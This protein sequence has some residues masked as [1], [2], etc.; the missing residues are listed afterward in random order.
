M[1]E[2]ID[3]NRCPFLRPLFRYLVRIGFL[4][5][6]N[7]LGLRNQC[8]RHMTD[9]SRGSSARNAYKVTQLARLQTA[10]LFGVEWI[11]AVKFGKLSCFL[12]PVSRFI[13][14]E[15]STERDVPE[16]IAAGSDIFHF[17]SLLSIL[18]YLC[19]YVA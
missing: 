9:Q 19:G 14:V 13:H 1:K 15:T 16:E 17:R 18:A 12:S 3:T 5:G 10:S 6:A 11:V 4:T 2:N 7:R 8:R